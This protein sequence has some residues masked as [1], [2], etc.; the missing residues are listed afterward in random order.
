MHLKL[1]FVGMIVMLTACN[2]TEQSN[3][4][5]SLPLMGTWE[6][7]AATTIEKDTSFSTFDAGRKMIKIINPTHFAFLNHAIRAEKDTSNAT[8][9]A[10]GGTYTLVDSIYTEQLE[11]FV[12]PAWE[13]K[14]FEFVVKISNDTLIQEGVEKIE[15]LGIDHVIVEK[16]KRVKE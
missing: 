12:D 10:G 2:Q 13:N 11:Y 14:T 8:F 7:I 4:P 16:Y 6:L 15:E 1:G 9:I 5:T 3:E